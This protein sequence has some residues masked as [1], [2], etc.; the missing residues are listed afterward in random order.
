MRATHGV[1][2]NGGTAGSPSWAKH[3]V[4]KRPGLDGRP[5]CLHQTLCSGASGN[6][7]RTTGRCRDK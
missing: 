4:H 5:E 6:T 3:T 7:G 2:A 1:R